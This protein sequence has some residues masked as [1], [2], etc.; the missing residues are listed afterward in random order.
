VTDVEAQQIVTTLT[1]SHPNMFVRLSAS[2]QRDTMAAYR[3]MLRDL[4]Y[5]TANAAV[6]RLLATLKY[7]PTPA[8]IRESAL[9]LSIGEQ[10][11]GGEQWGRV[12]TAIRE[13]GVHRTP[14]VDFV[15]ANET[16]ARCVQALGWTELCNSEN[17]IADRARFVDLFDKLA[18]QERRRLLSETLPAVKA[19]EA[20]QRAQLEERTGVG[21]A[22]IGELVGK[23]LRLPSGGG[24]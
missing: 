4:D 24:S 5:V 20:Q 9:T 22:S 6:A 1:A 3:T 16:T 17:T 21:G 2:Q 10:S 11:A 19:L 15:F 7:M 13:R 18:G 14:G 12:L 23:V 8:E